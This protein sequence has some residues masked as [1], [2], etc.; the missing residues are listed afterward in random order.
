MVHANVRFVLS[1]FI[2]QIAPFQILTA[3]IAMSFSEVNCRYMR[4]FNINVCEQVYQPKSMLYC[5]E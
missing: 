5:L 3:A 4:N 1:Q 2:K